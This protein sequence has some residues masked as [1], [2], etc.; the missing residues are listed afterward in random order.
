VSTFTTAWISYHFGECN[1]IDRVWEATTRS[2]AF[3]YVPEHP[4]YIVFWVFKLLTIVIFSSFNL[5][6]FASIYL[7]KYFVLKNQKKEAK[8]IPTLPIKDTNLSNTI[9]NVL[10]DDAINIIHHKAQ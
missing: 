3:S 1:E 7:V 6:P 8:L 2:W 10:L 5:A 9:D 4:L